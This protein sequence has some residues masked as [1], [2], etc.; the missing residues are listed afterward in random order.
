MFCYFLSTRVT[1]HR[2]AAAAVQLQATADHVAEYNFFL[3]NSV[4]VKL[5]L[6]WRFRSHGRV[7][8]KTLIFSRQIEQG[9]TELPGRHLSRIALLF[10]AILYPLKTKK[11]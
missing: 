11:N 4:V 6:K 7:C 8:T 2:R 10:I 3:S 9:V 1:R 5:K